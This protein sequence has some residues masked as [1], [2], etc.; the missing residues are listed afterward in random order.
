MVEFRSLL[1]NYMDSFNYTGGCKALY[2]VHTYLNTLLVFSGGTFKNRVEFHP[3]QTVCS[4]TFF[5][6]RQ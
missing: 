4:R 2:S 6:T 5:K 3:R 1:L